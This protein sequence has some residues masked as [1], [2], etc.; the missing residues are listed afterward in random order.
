MILSI[1]VL[2]GGTYAL[3]STSV[4]IKGHLQ[5]GNMALKLTRLTLNEIVDALGGRNHATVINSLEKVNLKIRTVK[6]FE[7]EILEIIKDIKNIK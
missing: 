7:A 4:T 6:N 2:A 3:F 1:A 5:A